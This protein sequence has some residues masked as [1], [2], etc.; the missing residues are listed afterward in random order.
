MFEATTTEK[1]QEKKI[2]GTALRRDFHV[3]VIE[4]TSDVRHVV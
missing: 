3:A 1:E 2:I 4:I